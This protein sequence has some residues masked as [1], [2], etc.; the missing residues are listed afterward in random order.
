MRAGVRSWIEISGARL[1][2]NF[3]AIRRA[4]ADDAEVVAVV[5]ADAYG[6]G[7]ELCAPVLARSGARWFGVTDA[8]EGA[9][10]RGALDAAGAHTARILVMSGSLPEETGQIAA[11]RLTPVIWTPAQAEA[12]RGVQGLPVH[13][14][15]DTGMSRQGA[16]PGAEFGKLL[17]AVR[18][19]GLR[20]EGV[21]TH[22]CSSEVV[23]SAVTAGQRRRFEEA[24]AQ[25]RLYDLKPE[26]LHV[27]NS[28]AVDQPF[29]PPG[30]MAEL[31]AAFGART[32]V[33]A[34]I[35]LYGYTLPI[36]PADAATPLLRPT[37]E[38]VL[39]WKARILAIREL[40]LGDT[41]GYGATFSAVTP[42][43]IALLPVGY[44][45][46]LRRELSNPGTKG[47]GGFVLARDAEGVAHRCPI[48]GRVSMNLTVVDISAVPGLQ[49]GDAVTLLG[50]GFTADD[51]AERAGTISYEILCALR[52]NEHLLVD[53]DD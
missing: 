11:S 53:S 12:L 2:R 18:S 33:R 5:K 8:A 21:F 38:P 20:I 37:L 39:T 10:V 51:H 52:S 3:H 9:R 17:A 45:D 7:A 48:L 44:A 49:P 46:G 1:A 41:V 31:A 40:A 4:A 24:I 47:L 23:G 30:W 29:A 22:L 6:H 32:M 14:E 27:A 19:A 15:L 35:A 36:E 25:L 50:D 28:S 13:V 34:G 16:R 42:M 26:W 43:R